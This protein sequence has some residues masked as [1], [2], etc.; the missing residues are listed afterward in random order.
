MHSVRNTQL[1]TTVYNG[2][3]VRIQLVDWTGRQIRRGKLGRIPDRVGPILER[4]GLNREIWCDL[5]SD[6]GRLFRRFAGRKETLQAEAK[7]RSTPVGY[8]FQR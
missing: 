6:F 1:N 2:S 4:L 3:G 8:R 7:K 5:V